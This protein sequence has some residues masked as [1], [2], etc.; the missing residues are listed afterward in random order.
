[1]KYDKIKLKP[2]V[3]NFIY[4]RLSYDK[5]DLI[6]IDAKELLNWKRFDLAFKLYY[7]SYENKNKKLAS[8]IYN[9]DIKCQSNN[10]FKEFGNDNKNSFDEI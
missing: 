7:L 1:M 5:Y 10:K 3:E 9:I 8:K 6:N 2:L 4:E